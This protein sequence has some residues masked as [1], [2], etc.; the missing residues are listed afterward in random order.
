MRLQ[1]SEGSSSLINI[2]SSKFHSEYSSLNELKQSYALCMKSSSLYDIKL[3]R[4]E[5]TELLIVFY[6]V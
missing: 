6:T 3:V 1:G 4:F 2:T 5:L